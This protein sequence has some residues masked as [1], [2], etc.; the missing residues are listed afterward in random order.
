VTN[1][2]TFATYFSKLIASDYTPGNPLIP[3]TGQ[4]CATIQTPLFGYLLVGPGNS[5][6]GNSNSSSN[7]WNGNWLAGYDT[8]N[9]KSNSGSMNMINMAYPSALGLPPAGSASNFQIQ[10]YIYNAAG[11]YNNHPIPT[12]DM[13]G[14]LTLKQRYTAYYKTVIAI[15]S[16]VTYI[17]SRIETDYQNL[18]GNG[19]PPTP[20]MAD[21]LEQLATSSGWATLVESESI[22]KV[23]RH[24]L[25]F[26]SQNFVVNMRILKNIE[27]LNISQAMTN[28]LL[29]LM[30]QRQ[31]N[32]LLRDA[33]GLGPGKG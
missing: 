30:N 29:I 13:Q 10:E 23:Q 6:T 9:Q 16:Y 26:I 22:G 14:S 3:C 17:L 21:N 15:Q 25:F 24:M 19:S 7:T 5:N 31:E 4:D 33:Q 1:S 11:L 18:Y 2:G 20:S 8:F 12:Q 27:E 32:Q 28:S